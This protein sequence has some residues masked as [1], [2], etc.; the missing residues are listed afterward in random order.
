LTPYFYGPGKLLL[1]DQVSN[2]KKIGY[3]CGDA[4]AISCFTS[5][6]FKWTLNI[7]PYQLRKQNNI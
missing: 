5:Y 1:K 7:N 6:N 2:G 4:K 3:G